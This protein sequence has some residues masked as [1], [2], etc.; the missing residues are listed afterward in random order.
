MG[1][2]IGLIDDQCKPTEET[3]EKGSQK[4]CKAAPTSFQS[5]CGEQW[6]QW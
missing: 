3:E 6:N 2:A 5:G 1:L 4:Y